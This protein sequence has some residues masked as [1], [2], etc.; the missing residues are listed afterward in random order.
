MVGDNGNVETLIRVVL[1]EESVYGVDNYTVLV[2]GRIE[3]EKSILAWL[4]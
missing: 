4:A 2:V 3:N 1:S